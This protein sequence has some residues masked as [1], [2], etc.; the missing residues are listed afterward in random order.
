MKV[1]PS[2]PIFFGLWNAPWSTTHHTV[3]YGADLHLVGVAFQALRARL[4]SR[5]PSGTQTAGLTSLTLKR[6]LSFF[7]ERPDSFLVILAIINSAPYRLN[8]FEGFRAE[9]E[10]MC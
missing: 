2:A 9:G 7:E 8:A 3:P 1:Y 4:L 5:Y 10:S 6:W